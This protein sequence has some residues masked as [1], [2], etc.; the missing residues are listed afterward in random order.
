V[1]EYKPLLVGNKYDLVGQVN[2][3][4][5]GDGAV[6][7]AEVAAANDRQGLTLVPISAQLEL[8]CPPYT[9]SNS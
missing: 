7:A 9:Q 3:D 1:D 8:L 5:D 4:A 6:T 2:Y